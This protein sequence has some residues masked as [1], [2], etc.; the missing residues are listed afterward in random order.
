MTQIQ[1]KKT[2]TMIDLHIKAWR[3]CMWLREK[4]T[5]KAKFVVVQFRFFIHI[6]T[7]F[8]LVL[9]ADGGKIC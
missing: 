5:P 1:Q 8:I 3:I 4:R 2:R 9:M 7:T 6:Q